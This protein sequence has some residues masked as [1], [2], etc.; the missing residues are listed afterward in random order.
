MDRRWNENGE[1]TY[2]TLNQAAVFGRSI[3]D[4]RPSTKEREYQMVGEANSVVALSPAELEEE[5]E[6]N[7]SR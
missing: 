1:S 3:Y 6:S 2:S 5:K 7:Q 4:Q